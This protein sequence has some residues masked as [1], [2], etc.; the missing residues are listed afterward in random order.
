MIRI[1]TLIFFLSSSNL[2]GSEYY[3]MHTYTKGWKTS[4]RYEFLEGRLSG[5]VLNSLDSI[6]SKIPSSY[7]F[8]YNGEE[9]QSY[10]PCGFDIYSID[11]EEVL[12]LKYNYFNRGYTCHSTPFV[13][14][15]T[16]YLLGGHGFWTNHFD[17]LRFDKI[18]GSWEIVKTTNQP[19][20]YVSSGVYQNSKGIFSLFGG[21]E[22][23][24]T[25]LAEKIP[26]GYFLDWESKVWREIEINIEGIDN[27]KLVENNGL[28]FLQTKDYF[29]IVSNS[30]MKN[31]GWNIIEK[32]SGKIFFF[33]QLKNEDVFISPF[34]E[35][36]GNKINY[37]SPNGTPKSLDIEI[38][39]SA[40]K[41]VGQIKIKEDSSEIGRLFPF[42]DSV[43][44]LIITLLLLII[45]YSHFRRNGTKPKPVSQNPIRNEEME[46]MIKSL[47]KFPSE[48]LTTQQL[49]EI[50][51]IDS[52]LNDDSK[53]LKRSR[54]INKLN[55]FQNSLNGKDLII[56][57]KSV[58]DKRFVYYRINK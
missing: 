23:F 2:L 22:N 14:D 55:E 57:D 58:E 33:D 44:I 5:K 13:R 31:M 40:S 29:F 25:G 43:Y 3:W 56:R 12:E 42:R 21:R 6:Y 41:E 35:V 11:E 47:S 20:D 49:D 18:H 24:R 36:I 38:L 1:F 26:N 54:W 37:Q 32:E 52:I 45:T 17:L 16:N 39:F 50:L 48:S 9:L 51:G 30:G 10:V 28:K 19:T 4:Y 34:I 8:F 7:F 53:R 27:E 46:T 15:S